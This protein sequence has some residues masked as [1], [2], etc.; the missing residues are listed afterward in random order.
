MRSVKPLHLVAGVAVLSLALA[1][2]SAPNSGAAANTPA[3]AASAG[4]VPDKPSAPVSLHILDVAG[5]QKL[6]GPMVDAFVKAH[7]DIISSV[8]W[9]SAGAP[10]LVGTIKP[11]VDSG[12]L[13]V[14][15]VMTGTD[16]LSAG[17][18]QNLWVPIVK[19]YGSRISNMANYLDPA[20]KME[21]L[22]D[23][24][25]VVTTYYPSGP[26]LQYDPK[27]VTNVPK[28]PEELL[29]WA[30][31]HPGKFGYARPANSGSGRTF[32]MGLPYMLGDK[33][34]SDPVNGWAKTWAYLKDLGQYINN[35]PTGTGA[36]ISQMADGTVAMVPT[37][38][39]WDINPRALGQEPA[40]IEAAAFSSFTWVTDAHYAVV[41]KGQSADKMAAIL[42][43]LQ[44]MLTPDVNAMA[45]DSGYFYPG[46]AV[47]GATLDKA[48]AAS[49][50]V[51]KKY[52]RDWYDA[53]IA[54]EPKAVPLTPANMV[55]AFDMWDRE[56][57]TGKYTAK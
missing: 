34:P 14:D 45:Y 4:A 43:L 53:L 23:G 16:G 2:C 9:E 5:N 1:A 12:N 32:L 25:G 22:A 47:K 39:G 37:T 44:Y 7:P 21:A 54:K 48:P 20:A 46:P 3:A 38:T 13:S 24:Y 42:D 28:T 29:A 11:Q 17:I 35:Y 40:S 50:E 49:Q 52:G 19:D 8:S 10:D 41:P 33:D 56:V 36:L 27:V 6:T 51:I 55:K 31:A 30:K 15:L 57:G 26:L 18:E